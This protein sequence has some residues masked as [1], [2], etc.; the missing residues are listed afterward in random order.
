MRELRLRRWPVS[1][2]YRTT[3]TGTVGVT[4]IVATTVGTVGTGCTVG[5]Q[6]WSCRKTGALVG[7]DKRMEWRSTA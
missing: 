1:V 5:R 7:V 6:R 2:D 3:G 4:N